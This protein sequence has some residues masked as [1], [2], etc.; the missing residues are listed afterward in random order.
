[1]VGEAGPPLTPPALLAAGLAKYLE[2]STIE[3]LSVAGVGLL[4]VIQ[5]FFV[6][7][8][9]AVRW[10]GYLLERGSSYHP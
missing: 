3:A 6:F 7:E 4:F 5:Q 8:L 2:A 1:M 9:H 10:I